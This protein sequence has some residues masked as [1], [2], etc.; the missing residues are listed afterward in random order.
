MNTPKEQTHPDVVIAIDPD[1]DKN[2]V[3]VY[4]TAANTLAVSALRFA[5]TLDMI[6]HI[7][8]RCTACGVGMHVYIEAGWLNG[9]NWHLNARD[10][11]A[12]AAAKGNSVGRNHETGRKLSEMLAH[13]DIPHS[14]IAP[15]GLMGHGR[16]GKLTAQDLKR[17]TGYSGR[18][19]QEGRDAA[20]I[21]WVRGGG[22]MD[23]PCAVEDLKEWEVAD[24]ER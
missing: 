6:S 20:L 23:R 21:A 3:A 22:R 9:G 4:D 5:H 17:L 1:C 10:S 14:L 7:Y 2:G 16:G 12:R 13:Y 15:L 8:R 18:S 11:P 19:N 24:V